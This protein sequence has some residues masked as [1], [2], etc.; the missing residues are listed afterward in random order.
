[1][2]YDVYILASKPQ[3]TL[4]SGVTNDLIRRVYEHRTDAVAGFTKRYD[5]HSLVYFESTEN[6]GSAIHREKRLKKYPRAWKC[7]LI[8]GAHPDW[9]DLNPGLA[10]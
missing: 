8:E 10:V 1:M 9:H 6:V 4:Y 3:G 7:P 2:P 5:V